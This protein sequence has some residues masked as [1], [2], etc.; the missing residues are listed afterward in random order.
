MANLQRISREPPKN[1]ALDYA[2]VYRTGLARVQK[3]AEETW[4]DYNDHDPGVTILQLLSYALTDIAYR[5]DLPIEDILA[6][7]LDARRD[8]PRGAFYTGEEILTSDPLTSNDYR[9]LIYDRIGPLKNAWLRPSR[10]SDVKGLYD[11]RLQPWKKDE[12]EGQQDAKYLQSVST[13]LLRKHRNIGE[14]FDSVEV[15]KPL[16]I[17]LEAEVHIGFEDTPEDILAAILFKIGDELI[18]FPQ[19][20][21]IDSRFQQSTPAD[22][23]FVGPQLNHGDIDDRY[24]E[25]LPPAVTVERILSIIRN[26]PSV[27]NIRNVA[28]T[29]QA[30]GEAESVYK[31]VPPRPIILPRDHVPYLD[32]QSSVDGLK[33]VRD[34][35]PK[36]IDHEIVQKSFDHLVRLRLDRELYASRQMQDIDYRRLPWGRHRNL[37][38]YSSIQHDFPIAYGLGQYGI[39]DLLTRAF[40]D[41]SQT[42]SQRAAQVRQLKAYLLFFEQLLANQLS[43]LA[44]V[45]ELF[46]LDA[47]LNQ[48][49]FWQEVTDPTDIG[50]VFGAT[51]GEDDGLDQYRQGLAKIIRRHDPHLDRRER[52]LDHLLAR[53]NERFEDEKLEGLRR[54]RLR[55]RFSGNRD[56]A[57]IRR[58]NS[59]LEEYVSLSGRRG[60]GVDYSMPA[61]YGIDIWDKKSGGPEAASAK[62]RVIL[63]SRHN[64]SSKRLRRARSKQMLSLGAV[65]E[66]YRWDSGGHRLLLVDAS[67]DVI[68]HSPDPIQSEAQAQSTSSE[69]SARIVQIAGMRSRERSSLIG[70][71]D[72]TPCNLERRVTLMAGCTTDVYLLEHVL[73]RPAPGGSS[74][75]TAST[76]G[77]YSLCASFLLSGWQARFQSIDYRQFAE[78]VVRDNCPAHIAIQCFWLSRE[79]MAEFKTLYYDWRAAKADACHSSPEDEVSHNKLL[80]KMD[81]LA[82]KL[83][84]FVNR[85]RS[86]RERSIPGDVH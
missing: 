1:S 33:V 56:E 6:P 45:P 30:A 58:K 50:S 41:D 15:L 77:F 76:S 69:I 37:Q 23:I 40:E 14:D 22:E 81:A 39:P 78:K 29:T 53:F 82:E 38:R 86:E 73:L 80:E 11:V 66:N 2:H 84:N 74:E 61:G 52:I 70:L 75:Q 8:S 9:K 7:A 34:G 48:T 65:S 49:Y 28:V 83:K 59:F 12:S 3:L 43:Q 27:L 5:V 18:P 17:T 46:S 32:V 79:D 25:D 54:E 44:N 71:L 51:A 64:V 10:S 68:A 36:D 72:P 13:A 67:G 21:N 85:Q 19:V 16:N 24:L 4:T 57:R 42:R 62:A 55:R 20:V 47:R 26:V 31:M 35:A 60:T 63:R